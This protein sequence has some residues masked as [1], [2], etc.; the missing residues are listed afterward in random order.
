[1]ILLVSQCLIIKIKGALDQIQNNIGAINSFDPRGNNPKSAHDGIKRNIESASSAL[2][3]HLTIFITYKLMST[4][5]YTENEV[6]KTITEIKSKKSEISNELANIKSSETAMLDDIKAVAGSTSVAKHS[7][8]FMTESKNHEKARKWWLVATVVMILVS[9]AYGVLLFF[10]ILDIASEYSQSLY[11]TVQISLAKIILFSMLSY[12]L[13]LCNKNYRVH[14]HLSE[15]NKHRHNALR[16]FETFIE[17]ANDAQTKNAILLQASQI[18][19][20]H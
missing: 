13:F 12:A 9:A 15:I 8:I 17:S 19:F 14:Q 6:E 11:A 18:I 4:K 1:M 3:T 16:T 7:E 5:S 2:L 20:N 10:N